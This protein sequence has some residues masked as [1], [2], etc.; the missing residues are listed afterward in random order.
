MPRTPSSGPPDRPSGTCRPRAWQ[1]AEILAHLLPREPEVRGLTALVSMSSPASPAAPTPT[2]DASRWRN[3]IQRRGTEP[4]STAVDPTSRRHMMRDSSGA[5]ISRPPSR[6]YIAPASTGPNRIH[7]CSWTSIVVSSPSP[8]PSGPSPGDST[9]CHSARR[10]PDAT[11]TG[12]PPSGVRP[13]RA[14]ARSRR[15]V[16]ASPIPGPSRATGRAWG[17]VP[18]GRGCTCRAP[19]ATPPRR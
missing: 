18:G 10:G 5:S 13:R 9:C 14:G 11:H 3:R 4:S 2:A 12:G 1:L 7:A 17:T 15:P 16:P 19:R 8:P 6:P